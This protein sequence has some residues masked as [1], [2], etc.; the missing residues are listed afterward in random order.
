[1]G[2]PRLGCTVYGVATI[3]N[4][5]RVADAVVQRA[6]G[7]TAN[8]RLDIREHSGLILVIADQREMFC[9]SNDGYVRLP[10]TVR[11]WCGLAPGDR[12][13]LAAN[14]DENLLF[15]YPPAT[16]DTLIVQSGALVLGGDVA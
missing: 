12:V 7:W 2:A 15:V 4:R 13:L 8:A 16:L 10:A 5:G 14:A 9:V 11:R 3:D 6:L 1:M